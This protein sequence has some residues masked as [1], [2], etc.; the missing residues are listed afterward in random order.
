MVKYTKMAAEKRTRGLDKDG[1]SAHHI[2]FQA[3]PWESHTTLKSLRLDDQL[4]A[5]IGPDEHDAIHN[6]V[7]HVPTLPLNL[8]GAVL[9]RF[10]R[11]SHTSDHVRAIGNLQR[12]IEG[13]LEHGARYDVFDRT[14]GEMAMY[15]LDL[16]KPMVHP[17]SSSEIIDLK[18]KNSKPSIL[19]TPRNQ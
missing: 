14:I 17:P 7:S 1:L 19:W 6:A 10:K 13:A 4:I 3:P 16:Q 12:S 18:Y 15:A 2:L 8:A 11:F 9:S 5:R